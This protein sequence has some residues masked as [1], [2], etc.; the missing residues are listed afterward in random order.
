MPPRFAFAALALLAPLAVAW[1]AEEEPPTMLLEPFPLGDVRLAEGR[2]L[3]EQ[4]RNHQYLLSLADD[5]LLYAF[6]LNAGLPTPGEPLRQWEDPVSEV[7]GH[8]VGHALSACAQMYRST[9]D[10]ALRA[11]GAYLVAELAEVQAALGGGYLS[12]YPESF[13]DRVETG[14]P[15]WAAYY[16]I[17]KIMAGLLDQYT[18]CGNAQALEVLEA[19]VAYLHKRNAKFETPEALRMYMDRNEEG[20]MCDVLWG[21]YGVTGNPAA[22]E[23]AD[24]MEKRSFLDPLARGEDV[25][26]RLHGNTHIPLA[27]GALRRYERT[28]EK[29]YLYTGEFFWDRVATARSFATGGST[30]GEVWGEPFALAAH[31]LSNTTHE[32]CKTHNMLKLS[33]QLLCLTGEAKYAEFMERAFLNGILGTQGP[34]PGQLEYYVPQATGY[35]R[36]FGLP[37]DAFWC[38]YGTGVETWSRLT[39]SIYF[40]DDDSLTVSQFIASTLRWADKGVEIEQIT[41][42]P[43]EEGAAFV[44]GAAA[45][46]PFTLRVRIPEWVAGPVRVTVNGE[47]QDQLSPAPGSFLALEREWRDGDRVTLSLPMALHA[48]PMP[49]DPNLV[50]LMYGPVVL[51]GLLD[52]P[53]SVPPATSSS[54]TEPMPVTD[55]VPR[56]AFLADTVEDLSWLERQGEGLVFQTVGQPTEMTFVPFCEV[57]GERYGLYWPVVPEGSDRHAILERENEAI[58]FLREARAF[59]AGD[60]LEPLHEVYESLAS[61]PT[62]AAYESRLALAMASV[63]GRAGR[64]AEASELLEPLT[65]PFIH[66]DM[67]GAVYEVI[68]RPTAD[69]VEGVQPLLV[70]ASS[71]DGSH[72]TGERGGR[73]C[74]ETRVA[75]GQGHLYF[76]VA[77]PSLLRGGDATVTASIDIYSDGSPG[78]SLIVQYD[79]L[80]ADSQGGGS[81]TSSEPIA[82]PEEVGWHTV[83]LELPRA[84]LAGRQNLGS[85]FRLTCVGSGDIA[86]GDVRLSLEPEALAAVFGA[87]DLDEERLV[88]RVVV[89][90]EG[91]ERSHNLRHEGGAAGPH[92]GRFWRHAEQWMSW[93]LAVLP[94]APMV[95][96]VVYWG[97]DRGRSFDVVVDDRVLATQV[98]EGSGP[99]FVA[100]EYA[101]PMDL[102]WGKDRVTVKFARKEV[103]AGGV[104]DCAMLRAQP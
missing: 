92:L 24:K 7:R 68:G 14:K 61:D 31:G 43:Y 76:S 100:V 99:R 94:D 20:G 102:T 55:L 34:E 70:T 29:R 77:D 25:L 104:F 87:F 65:R 47:V 97:A 13:L 33:R 46:V 32:T 45:P 21:L 4:E 85:D 101:V 37:L 5:S 19:M 90:D 1:A 98:L 56:Y 41:R 58:A 72:V 12:A 50:A 15:V 51:A 44:V 17:H 8:F 60:P 81:Y 28:G 52:E 10:E 93:D 74:V 23:L 69:Q 96:R 71:W 36:V 3:E 22:A 64:A 83:T 78:R 82:V 80:V 16:T 79:S 73:A 18:L 38:C 67:A 103:F 42:F 88:D 40:H 84:H 49:D 91:S 27:I 30:N 2:L 57:V 66:R 26:A 35:R 9:G 62:L 53:G 39:D 11:K 75:R 63:L 95:L 86:V 89:G 54:A 59:A 48:W 6:R